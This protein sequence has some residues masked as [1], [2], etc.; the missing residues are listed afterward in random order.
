MIFLSFTSIKFIIFLIMFAGIYYMVP[1]KYRWIVLFIA[2]VIFYL[3]AGIEKLPIIVLTSLFVFLSARQINKVYEISEKEADMKQLTGRQRMEFLAPVKKKCRNSYLIPTIVLAVGILCYCKIGT[4]VVEIL[5]KNISDWT[6][7]DIIVPLGVSYYTF[8]NIGYLLD[9]Y[10]RK[11]KPIS[12]YFKF[13]LCVAYFPHIVQGPIAR[14]HKLSDEIFKEHPFDFTQVCFGIQLMLYG[15]FKKLV[16]ADRLALF[17]GQVFGSV[18]EY[19]GLVIVIALIFSSFQVYMDFSGCMDIVQGAS[20]IFGIKLADNFNHPF[21][22]K[23]AAE[24]WRRWHITLGS[25]YKDYVYLPVVTS[26]LLARITTKVKEKKGKE[27]AKKVNS[28]IPPAVVWLLTGLWHGTGWNYIVWG[29]YW[30]VI[31]ISSTIFAKQYKK[32]TETLH[33]DTTTSVYQCF[34]MLRT[35]LIFT[36]GRLITV[37]GTIRNTIV[38]IGQM[39]KSFNP[40]IFW[41]GTLYQMGIDFK[42]ICVIIIGLLFVRKI[43]MLQENASVREMIA[44]RNIVLRWA[45]YYG[46]IFTIIIFGIYGSGYNASDFIYANF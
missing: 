34:Q 3:S 44:K 43:S 17:T 19:E 32:I 4:R 7:N 6:W 18:A 25:W 22:S 33:I 45:I 26:G 28:A 39:F 41:D 35:F 10:W 12:N 42:D 37:P 2:S 21:F 20:Q 31:T 38:T 46:A 8:S 36:I 5:Q 16:I 11:Q 14:Y 40:W 15:Y 1:K 13:L 24:F 29:V 9:I 27:L 30:G 23:S